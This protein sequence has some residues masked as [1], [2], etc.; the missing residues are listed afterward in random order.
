MRERPSA[1]A[2]HYYRCKSVRIPSIAT[3]GEGGGGR[4]VG[5]V[6]RNPRFTCLRIFLN[7]GF[8]PGQSVVAGFTGAR[9]LVIY[10]TTVQPSCSSVLVNFRRIFA[11]HALVLCAAGPKRPESIFS[12]RASTQ[13]YRRH[14]WYAYPSSHRTTRFVR[15]ARRRIP[16]TIPTNPCAT[17]RFFSRRSA[18]SA[19]PVRSK[20]LHL[21]V[22]LHDSI[23]SDGSVRAPSRA[24]SR[25]GHRNAGRRRRPVLGVK[26]RLP[27]PGVGE[28]KAGDLIAK[29]CVGRD[30]VSFVQAVP[31][32]L[33]TNVYKMHTQ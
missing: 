3:P 29:L 19:L 32:L 8:R 28:P 15:Y 14:S 12:C 27:R 2:T 6:Y 33:H 10:R 18:S 4:G 24:R 31:H 9:L 5:G 17:N 26:P 13:F 25:R 7:N 11:A 1:A 23:A 22:L 20:C 30:D 16:L 21:L